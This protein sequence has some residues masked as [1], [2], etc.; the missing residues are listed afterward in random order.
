MNRA[1]AQT[2]IDDLISDVADVLKSDP[3]RELCVWWRGRLSGVV[4]TV[5]AAADEIDSQ[6]ADEALDALREAEESA[7]A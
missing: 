7:T 2:I 5:K 4:D 1:T 3:R 6:K